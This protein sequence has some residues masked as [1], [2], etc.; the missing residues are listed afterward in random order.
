MDARVHSIVKTTKRKQSLQLVV[1]EPTKVGKV[2]KF[3]MM[4]VLYFR[5]H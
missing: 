1:Q 3:C 5:K 4:P 2:P